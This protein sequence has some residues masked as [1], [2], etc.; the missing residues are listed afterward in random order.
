MS[1]SSTNV[2][3]ANFQSQSFEQKFVTAKEAA[4]FVSYSPDYVS[5][6]AREGKVLAEQRGRQWFVSLDSLKQFSQ[7]QE[8]EQRARKEELREARIREYAKTKASAVAEEQ[9]TQVAVLQPTAILFTTAVSMCVCLLLLLGV[10]TQ[11]AQ[12][13]VAQLYTGAELVSKTI[14]TLAPHEVTEVA[15]SSIAKPTYSS[16]VVE[17]TETGLLVRSGGT[18]SDIISD[19][20]TVV[21]LSERRAV[22]TPVFLVSPDD[23]SVVIE[24]VPV[25]TE[26]LPESP[27]PSL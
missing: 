7:Q 22:L 14:A 24:L 25:A 11:Q 9:A 2:T 23:E 18:M 15:L 4:A 27:N 3:K 8:A 13:S 21:P 12:L 17:V 20:I 19:D 16:E 10:V 26:A 1:H 5:R 6:L